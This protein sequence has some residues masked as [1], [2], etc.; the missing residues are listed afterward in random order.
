M[1]IVR[2]NGD[3]PAVGAGNYS[4]RTR[5]VCADGHGVAILTSTLRESRIAILTQRIDPLSS[6]GLL[7]RLG[8]KGDAH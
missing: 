7:P 8:Y 1:G 3:E 4:R 5:V 6:R 2:A